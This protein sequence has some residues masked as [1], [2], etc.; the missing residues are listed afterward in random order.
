MKIRCI[1][2]CS[3]FLLF[4]VQAASAC[5]G[6]KRAQPTLVDGAA[7][8]SEVA[9]VQHSPASKLNA[10]QVALPSAFARSIRES[11]EVIDDPYG[12]GDVD[13]FEVTVP[14]EGIASSF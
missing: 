14:V 13:V 3:I 12:L 1:G 8:A 9:R 2:Y 6:N 5:D 10:E 4:A 11:D 7:P